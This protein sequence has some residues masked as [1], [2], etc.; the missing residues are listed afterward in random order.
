MQGP[1]RSGFN[2]LLCKIWHLLPVSAR[3]SFEYWTLLPPYKNVKRWCDDSSLTPDLH[4]GLL[5][6]HIFLGTHYDPNRSDAKW[7]WWRDKRVHIRSHT[8]SMYIGVSSWELVSGLHIIGA[9][10]FSSVINHD[11]CAGRA[12]NTSGVSKAFP[13]SH[14]TCYT[15][16]CAIFWPVTAAQIGWKRFPRRGLWSGAL[17]LSSASSLHHIDNERRPDAVCWV[18]WG[19]AQSNILAFSV[20]VS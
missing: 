10:Y 12:V 7:T 5:L 6:L 19:R 2:P 14:L 3:I 8:F 17:L 9:S 15:C 18:K 4:A 13:S 20:H 11:L 16:R 1:L